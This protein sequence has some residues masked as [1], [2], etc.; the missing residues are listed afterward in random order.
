MGNKIVGWTQNLEIVDVIEHWDSL[1]F[2]FP[3][4]RWRQMVID[5]AN[6]GQIR[7]KISQAIAHGAP[8]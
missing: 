4:N 6:V 1:M 2:Q 5:A 3:E 7:G 8:R